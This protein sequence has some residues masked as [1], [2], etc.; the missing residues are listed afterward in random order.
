MIHSDIA[1]ADACLVNDFQMHGLPGKIP[2]IEGARTELVVVMT[3]GASQHFAVRHKL[4]GAFRP[5]AA[6]D[7]ETDRVALHLERTADK[8]SLRIVTRDRHLGI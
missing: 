4:Q 8:F 6:A 1:P 2:D 3:P 5:V 7:Q